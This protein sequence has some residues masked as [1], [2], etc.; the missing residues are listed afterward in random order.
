VSAARPA[1]GPGLYVHV[2]FCSAICPYCDFAVLRGGPHRHGG[3]VDA[4]VREAHAWSARWPLAETPFDTVYLGGGTPSALAPDLLARIFDGLREA[5][6]IRDDAWISLEANPEDTTPAALAAWRALG[7]RTVSLGVQSFDDRALRFLGR[8]HDAAAA[9]AAVED[10]VVAGFPIVNVDLIYGLPDQTPA[11]WQSELATATGLGPQHLSC[12]Q[13]TIHEGTPFGFRRDRG[14]LSELPEAGQAD[15]FAIAHQDLAARGW[16]GYEVS[17]FARSPELRSRTIATIGATSPTSASALRRTAST[18]LAAGGTRASS[19]RGR[20]P[21]RVTAPRW[22]AARSSPGATSP[23]SISSSAC[24]ATG[25]TWN[26]SVGSAATWKRRPPRRTSAA[27]WKPACSSDLR[28][29]CRPLPPAG[30]SPTAWPRTSPPPPN[31]PPPG[32]PTRRVPNSKPLLARE[33]V[34]A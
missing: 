10:A 7:V 18:A 31:A 14:R 17:N 4:L 9:R 16:P 23:S 12:Y 32:D 3:F 22:P 29:G 24:E 6:P 26:G 33:T 25:S 28:A 30:R 21:S 20:P 11:A 2:P 15:L 13:L 34:D 1:E 19:A 8:R 27:R 5:L